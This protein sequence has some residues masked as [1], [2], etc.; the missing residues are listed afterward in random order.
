MPNSCQ[1]SH[2]SCLKLQYLLWPTAIHSDCCCKT[3]CSLPGAKQ[4][5]TMDRNREKQDFSSLGIYPPSWNVH[6]KVLSHTYHSS[7]ALTKL[8]Q[9]FTTL[10]NARSA[11]DMDHSCSLVAQAGWQS[12]LAKMAHTVSD[13]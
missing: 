13:C 12:C 4:V 5:P 3:R 2:Y 9:C 1:E 6:L 11:V 8:S 7:S 10:R